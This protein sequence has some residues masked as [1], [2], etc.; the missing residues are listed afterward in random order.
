MAIW[1]R[2]R[3]ADPALF[4]ND[5]PRQGHTVSRFRHTTPRDETAVACC[6]ITSETPVTVSVVV[7][8][9]MK[10]G[11]SSMVELQP[12]MHFHITYSL[13]FVLCSAV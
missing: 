11:K 7:T 3:Y 8:V 5:F 6:G 9:C 10:Q 2:V 1:A 13:L 12:A 4:A